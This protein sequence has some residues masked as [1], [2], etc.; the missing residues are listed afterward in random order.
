MDLV[1][2]PKN[3]VLSFLEMTLTLKITAFEWYFLL[4]HRHISDKESTVAI[5]SYGI[6]ELHKSIGSIEFTDITKI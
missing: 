5:T 1:G 6:G 4:C 2:S 3:S